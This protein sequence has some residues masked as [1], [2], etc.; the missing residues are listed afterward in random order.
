MNR[1]KWE[2]I[3]RDAGATEVAFVEVD[4]NWFDPGLRAYCNSDDCAR[5]G[6]NY[7]CPPAV[8][9]PETVIEEALNY[10]NAMIYSCVFDMEKGYNQGVR[11]MALEELHGMGDA[12]IRGGIRKKSQALMLSAGGCFHCTRCSLFRDMECPEPNMR[13]ASLSACCIRVQKM[14]NDAGIVYDEGMAH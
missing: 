4:K 2:Q 6:T 3:L 11:Q 9:E 14:S 12:L 5:F 1:E 10:E 8:G 13:Q 7:G